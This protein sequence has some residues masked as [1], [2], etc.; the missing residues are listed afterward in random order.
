LPGCI[1]YEDLFKVE[2][3]AEQNIT[4]ETIE[5]L[6]FE[7]SEDS[8]RAYQKIED[9]K[10][11]VDQ[12]KAQGFNTERVQDLILMAEQT[13]EAQLALEKL[14]GRPDYSNIYLK[15]TEVSNLRSLS[16]QISDE[17]INLRNE[18]NTL[19]DSLNK[20]Q[21][22]ENFNLARQEFYDERYEKAQE[23]IDKTY[24]DMSHIIAGENLLLALYDAAT[25]TIGN[26]LDQ[27]KYYIVSGIIILSVVF[28]FLRNYLKRYW[29]KR[30]LNKIK[31]EKEVLKQL[32]KKTQNEYF[33]NKKMPETVFHI[34][35]NK[36]ADLIR[37]IDRQVPILEEEIFKTNEKI[38]GHKFK[39]ESKSNK[40]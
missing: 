23:L 17:L 3:P 1:P 30:Q 35:M 6:I 38:K 9:S 2:E 26:F 8:I 37:D 7:P 18:I 13:Y 21:L 25:K 33:E 39:D 15:A 4:N 20:T 10:I 32:I 19:D 16:F 29:L 28:Y 40:K 12:M 14:G 36:F 31:L 34:R 27:N 24:N 22:N 11:L 5:E